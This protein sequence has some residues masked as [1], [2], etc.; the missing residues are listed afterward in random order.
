MEKEEER[1]PGVIGPGEFDEG[2]A[3]VLS[4]HR[5]SHYRVY[6]RIVIAGGASLKVRRQQKK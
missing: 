2:L 3:V 5:G 6:Y 4:V 1:T